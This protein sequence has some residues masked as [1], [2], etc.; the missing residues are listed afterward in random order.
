MK[1]ASFNDEA[2]LS[3]IRNDRNNNINAK[4]RLISR[5]SDAN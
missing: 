5:V 1:K 2:I 4:D 3:I